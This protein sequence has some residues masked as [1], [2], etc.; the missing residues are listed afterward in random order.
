MS[1][2]GVDPPSSARTSENQYEPPAVLD[3]GTVFE[4]TH[5]NKQGGADSNGQEN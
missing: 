3:F 4:T 5:G 2:N 1:D